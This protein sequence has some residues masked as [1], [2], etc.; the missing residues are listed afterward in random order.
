MLTSTN[1]L[2]NRTE[3]TNLKVTNEQY[4]ENDTSDAPLLR[5]LII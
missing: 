3:N 5:Y 1:P 4:S 2:T